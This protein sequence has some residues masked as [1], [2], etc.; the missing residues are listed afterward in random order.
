MNCKSILVTILLFI[1][2]FITS[3]TSANSN[4]IVTIEWE[5]WNELLNGKMVKFD[6]KDSKSIHKFNELISFSIDNKSKQIKTE[7]GTSLSVKINNVVEKNIKTFITNSNWIKINNVGCK[8][9][10]VIYIIH[11][12]ELDWNN[13]STIKKLALDMV[14]FCGQKKEWL[15]ASI[16]HNS[17]KDFSCND[18]NCNWVK[19]VLKIK[20]TDVKSSNWKKVIKNINSPGWDK[21]VEYS[22]KSFYN[23]NYNSFDEFTSGQYGIY[24]KKDFKMLPAHCDIDKLVNFTLD[25]FFNVEAC[26]DELKLPVGKMNKTIKDETEEAHRK[27]ITNNNLNND[28]FESYAKTAITRIRLIINLMLYVNSKTILNIEKTDN[29]LFLLFALKVDYKIYS[30]MKALY[31]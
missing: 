24:V 15:Y 5:K 31:K 25:N 11:E 27:A 13:K 23:D 6:T 4:T 9:S 26:S 1:S 17:T 30:N 18:L 12:L 20:A 2:F 16:R 19:E 14:Q 28:Y 3:Y 8:K 21:W 10:K 7:D 29:E 22:I